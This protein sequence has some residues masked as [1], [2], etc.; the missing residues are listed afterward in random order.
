MCR[1]KSESVWVEVFVSGLIE[2]RL[3]SFQSLL[4]RGNPGLKLPILR[5]TE[6]DH[7]D[8]DAER[9]GSKTVVGDELVNDDV[10]MECIGGQRIVVVKVMCQ[11]KR[12]SLL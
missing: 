7:G 1:A 2:R 5:R 9:G 11:A 12:I 3:L 10:V 6:T 4:G 8:E